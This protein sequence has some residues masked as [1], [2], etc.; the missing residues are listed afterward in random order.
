MTYVPAL[1]SN[2]DLEGVKPVRSNSC[3][4]GEVRRDEER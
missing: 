2:I 4:K 1:L 3:K